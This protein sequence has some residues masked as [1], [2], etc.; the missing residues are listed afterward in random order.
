MPLS[1][2]EQRMLDEL[3]AQLRTEDPRLDTHLR[4]SRPGGVS[5]RRV[6]LGVAIAVAGLAVVL[7]GVSLQN[8]IVGVVG[9]AVMGAGV[10][11]LSSRGSGDSSGA[12]R[13]DAGARAAAGGKKKESAFMSRLEQQWDERRGQGR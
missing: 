8:V 11:V 9:V 5:V 4:D 2:R 12:G 13:A 7:L 10:Y 3:E 1:E 6:V